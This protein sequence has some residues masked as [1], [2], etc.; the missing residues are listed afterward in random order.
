MGWTVVKVYRGSRGQRG[1]SREE[2]R[3]AF[4]AR[5]AGTASR[6]QGRP[7][8]SV[9]GETELGR[10]LPQD[11]VGF[12]T[13]VH[14]LGVLQLVPASKQGIDTT[15][16]GGK[17][18]FQMMGVFAEF[19][20]AMGDP[21]AGEEGG[22]GARKGRRTRGWAADPSTPGKKLR[23][24]PIW[25]QPRDRDHEAR[26]ST[27]G[28]RGDRSADQGG[29]CGL[30]QA[31]EAAS[32]A[33]AGDL[34]GSRVYHPGGTPLP[35]PSWVIRRLACGPSTGQSRWVAI[36]HPRRGQA[37]WAAPRPTKVIAKRVAQRSILRHPGLDADRRTT[38]RSCRRST[39]VT[40]QGHLG[41]LPCRDRR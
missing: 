11:L 24:G 7:D 36:D 40:A 21:R 31:N 23:S 4:D 38:V 19:E 39:W 8:S 3:P 22:V 28:W 13:E 17:A 16:P 30:R 26:G 15:T 34:E 37:Q 5:Y 12:L 33:L 10:S 1:Q 18:L 6:R 2:N 41:C 27:W 9:V 32:T 14:A 20:R 35:W 25:S 29:A